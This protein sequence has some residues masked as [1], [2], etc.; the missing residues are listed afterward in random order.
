MMIQASTNGAK[1]Q[2]YH[3]ILPN[4][5][6][7]YQKMIEMKR[8]GKLFVSLLMSIQAQETKDT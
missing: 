3:D 7:R 1:C 2:Y 8:G 6:K 4:T 5:E